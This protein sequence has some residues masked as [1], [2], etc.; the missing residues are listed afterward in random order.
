MLEAKPTSD[1]NMLAYLHADPPEWQNALTAVRDVRAAFG[2]IVLS[3]IYKR[4][5]NS[6]SG[7]CRLCVPQ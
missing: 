7:L 4:R 1:I 5:A 2:D 3:D 6:A